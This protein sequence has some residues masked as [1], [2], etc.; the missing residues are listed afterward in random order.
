MKWENEYH[1]EEDDEQEE[2][3]RNGNIGGLF[4]LQ[5]RYGHLLL[6]K[7]KIQSLNPSHP[8]RL[9]AANQLSMQ[10]QKL[11]NFRLR[12]LIEPCLVE[13]IQKWDEKE[14]ALEVVFEESN[15][16]LVFVGNAYAILESAFEYVSLGFGIK[17]HS[18]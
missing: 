2:R 7:L 16:G 9:P 17:R 1:S 4:F 10:V 15:I 11:G 14:R 13:Q 8:W 18:K 12:H 3:T 5:T 6:W